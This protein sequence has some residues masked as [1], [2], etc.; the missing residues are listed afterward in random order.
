MYRKKEL[1]KSGF[2]VINEAYVLFIMRMQFLLEINPVS[3][4][5]SP[6]FLSKQ[7]IFGLHPEFDSALHSYIPQ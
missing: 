2:L 6:N 5:N 3:T 1:L 7:F 4:M